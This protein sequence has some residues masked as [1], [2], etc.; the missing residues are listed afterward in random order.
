MSRVHCLDCGTDVPV[1]PLGHCPAGHLLPAKGHMV[2]SAIGSDDHHP[3]EPE[4]WVGQ[5]DPPAAEDPGA[6]APS[7]QP[8]AAPGMAPAE[9]EPDAGDLLRE[10]GALGADDDPGPPT[11]TRDAPGPSSPPPSTA[12]TNGH[13]AGDAVPPASR[14]PDTAVSEHSALEQAIQSLDDSH[15]TSAAA[16]QQPA[17]APAPADDGL[18]ALF[19]EIEGLGDETTGPPT[20]AAPASPAPAPAAPTGETPPPPPAPSSEAPT[21]QEHAPQA[22]P[23]RARRSAPAAQPQGEARS[24]VATLASQTGTDQAPDDTPEDAGNAAPRS[25]DTMNFTAKG[26]DMNGRRRRR[27]FGR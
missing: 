20:A 26:G 11:S 21:S 27:I 10:L 12:A 3:D 8:Q 7:A 23:R 25:V 13:A 6:T 24:D 15:S 9:R 1:D 18:A 19:D 14:E 22:P 4:P 5:V 17:P 16:P 2:E